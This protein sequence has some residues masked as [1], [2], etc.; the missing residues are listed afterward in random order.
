MRWDVTAAALRDVRGDG[1]FSLGVRNH[2]QGADRILHLWS[3]EATSTARRP[4]LL[5]ER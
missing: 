5:V 2:R 1:M 4:R 3:R